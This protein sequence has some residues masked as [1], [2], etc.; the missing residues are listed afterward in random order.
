MLDESR[1]MGEDLGTTNSEFISGTPDYLKPGTV[2]K[3]SSS[4]KKAF[5]YV[6]TESQQTTSGSHSPLQP[7]LDKQVKGLEPP[8]E[9][10][11]YGPKIVEARHNFNKLLIQK[12]GKRKDVVMKTLLR[13]FNRFF[14]YGVLSVQNELDQTNHSKED[15]TM[16]ATKKL[17]MS[18]SRT[19]ELVKTFT[20]ELLSDLG[21]PTVTLQRNWIASF[22][23]NVIDRRRY[24]I[25]L[26]YHARQ[27][28]QNYTRIL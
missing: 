24:T 25:P 26:K 11:T 20:D 12:E 13:S 17:L 18:Q 6:P 4:N 3:D 15:L 14:K 2:F 21:D 16:K 22:I 23:L 7:N 1:A 10:S 19:V 5:H 28:H 9:I 27:D 8:N